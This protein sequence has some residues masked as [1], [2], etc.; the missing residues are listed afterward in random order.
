MRWIIAGAATAALLTASGAMAQDYTLTP[1]YGRVNLRAGFTP[2]PHSVSMTAGGSIDISRSSAECRGRISNA[3]DYQ[4]T[5]EAGSMPLIFRVD[6]GV[7]TTLVINGPDA[8][9]ACDDDS[10]DGVNPEVRYDSPRSGRYDIW[11]GTYG[12]RTAPA[13]LSV[14]EL[15]S[16]GSY[17]GDDYGSNNG[18]IDYGLTAYFGEVYLNAGFTPDPHRVSITAG[19]SI[20]TSTVADGCQGQVSAAPDYQITYTAGSLPLSI[21]TNSSTDTTLLVSGPGGEWYCDDDSAGDRNA[22][23]RLSKPASG[24]YDIWVGTYGGGTASADLIITE[25][26]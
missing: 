7:D 2:D 17:N 3:P 6:S 4:V 14:S 26:R 25:R 8:R 19:G 9:W 15:S 5:Y 20:N 22:E 24:V 18:T 12:D 23:V 10:G 1:N 16:G 11:V 13:V 21:R